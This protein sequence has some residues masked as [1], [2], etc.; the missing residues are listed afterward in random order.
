[1]FRN[2][3]KIVKN[4][5]FFLFFILQ[6]I[7]YAVAQQRGADDTQAFFI[8]SIYSYSLSKG[9]AYDWLRTL[10]TQAGPRISGSPAAAAAVE[11]MRQ[12]M[13]TLGFDK[14]YLQPCS[15]PRW[16]RGAA[17]QV[18]IGRAHV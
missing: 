3:T 4:T 17:E 8:K 1:M 6:N 9:L 14:V 5:L 13:D 2:N 10:C 7:N 18:Q 15:V 12:T 16:V 11:L